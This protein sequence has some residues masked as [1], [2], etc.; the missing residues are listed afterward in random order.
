MV[1]RK[2]QKAK[3]S[4]LFCNF[5]PQNI[6]RT[7]KGKI[8]WKES[9]RERGEKL[10]KYES[11][12]LWSG[13]WYCSKERMWLLLLLI[14]KANFFTHHSFT[15]STKRRSLLSFRLLIRGPQTTIGWVLLGLI[16]TAILSDPAPYWAE[17]R[18]TTNRTG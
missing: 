12:K 3:K 14:P 15:F 9:A 18:W 13:N 1:N 8:F 4:S 17:F 2:I 10:K 5:L 7:S 11:E 6:W 16:W